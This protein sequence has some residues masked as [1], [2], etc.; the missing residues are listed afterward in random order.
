MHRCSC[1][2]NNT[3]SSTEWGRMLT[4]SIWPQEQRQSLEKRKDL[5]YAADMDGGTLW[6]NY[7]ILSP[8]HVFG[9]SLTTTN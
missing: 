4:L 2:E 7:K 1:M 9:D 8:P 3:Q 6:L 5:A